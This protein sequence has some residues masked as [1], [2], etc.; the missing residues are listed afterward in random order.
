M[1]TRRRTADWIQPPREE[2]VL[3]KGGQGTKEGRVTL[4]LI[5][6]K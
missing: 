3:K 5:T 4:L 1:A 6:V 2:N